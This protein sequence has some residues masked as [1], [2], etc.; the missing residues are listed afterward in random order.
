[1]EPEPHYLAENGAKKKEAAP[2]PAP[3]PALSYSKIKEKKKSKENLLSINF[4]NFIG[5]PIYA[6]SSSVVEPAI[7]E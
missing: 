3:T 2:A 6:E 5:K 1:M 4:Q 7:L